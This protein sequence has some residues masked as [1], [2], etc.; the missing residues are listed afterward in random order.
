MWWVEKKE[1]AAIII[2]ISN[3]PHITDGSDISSCGIIF[4]ELL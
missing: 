4:R 3:E 2:G 1:I